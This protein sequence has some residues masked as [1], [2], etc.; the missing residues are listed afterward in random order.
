MPYLPVPNDLLH[1]ASSV[2]AIAAAL[3][4][5]DCFLEPAD[6]FCFF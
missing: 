6:G 4:I 5:R 3:V 2:L 1:G